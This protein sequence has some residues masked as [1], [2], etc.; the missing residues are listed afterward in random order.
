MKKIVRGKW[1]GNTA[2]VNLKLLTVLSLVVIITGIVYVNRYF[3]KPAPGPVVTGYTTAE[4]DLIK[5]MPMELMAVAE[6]DKQGNLCFPGKF[7]LKP[8]VREA[9]KS[10]G[11]EQ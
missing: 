4:G 8:I 10:K 5:G 2:E 9:G 1:R 6:K 11:G 3:D 7:R